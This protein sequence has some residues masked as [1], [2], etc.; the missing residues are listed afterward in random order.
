MEITVLRSDTPENL[1]LVVQAHLQVNG[2]VDPMGYDVYISWDF[3]G[4]GRGDPNRSGGQWVAFILIYQ[5]K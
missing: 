5:E 1:A 4:G 3:S 2:L